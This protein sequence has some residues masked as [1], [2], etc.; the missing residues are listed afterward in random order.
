MLVVASGADRVVDNEATRELA[1]RVPGIALCF[2]PGAQ[3]EILS[4]RDFYRRQFL[5]AFD[6]FLAA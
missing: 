3:H 1:R 5:A 2:V 4:E 6:S